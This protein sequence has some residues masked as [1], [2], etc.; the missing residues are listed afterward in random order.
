MYREPTNRENDSGWCLLAGNESG[1]Y[2]D[3]PQNVVLMPLR[4][5]IARA[6]DIEQLLSVLA[7]VAFQ[8]KD[9]GDF[10]VCPMPEPRA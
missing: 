4:D 3:D 7:P 6:P 10:V 5:V 9:G 2:L 8:R 1:E